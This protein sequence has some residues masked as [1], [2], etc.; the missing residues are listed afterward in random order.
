ML[1]VSY[2]LDSFFE[3]NLIDIF[4]DN[5]VGKNKYFNWNC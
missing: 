3:W 1:G 5:V 2:N 4:L